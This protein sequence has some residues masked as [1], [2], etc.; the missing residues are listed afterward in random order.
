MTRLCAYLRFANRVAGTSLLIA[1]WSVLVVAFVHHMVPRLNYL[2]GA[3]IAPDK[4]CGRPQCDFSVFWPAG[5][6][7]AHKAFAVIYTP[8][9]FVAAAKTLLLPRIPS[10]LFSILPL[11]C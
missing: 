3:P 9:L 11:L 6:L 10:R 1:F 7:S 2:A 4:P 5:I 8:D